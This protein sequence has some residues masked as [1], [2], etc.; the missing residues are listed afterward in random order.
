MAPTGE[1]VIAETLRNLRSA[2][3]AILT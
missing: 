2:G 3:L 1:Y